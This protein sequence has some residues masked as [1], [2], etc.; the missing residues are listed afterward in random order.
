M[1]LHP[2][3]V[4]GARVRKSLHGSGLAARRGGADSCVCGEGGGE[5]VKGGSV[6]R[7]KAASRLSCRL[8]AT[9]EEPQVEME[10]DEQEQRRRKVEAGRAKVDGS[11][12]L[13][14][15]PWRET[16]RR[17]GCA[18][19]RSDESV[20]GG[21]MGATDRSPFPPPL[22]NSL[23][24]RRHLESTALCLAP[25]RCGLSQSATETHDVLWAGRALWAGPG[26]LA[27]LVV[28]LPVPVLFPRG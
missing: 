5:W 9:G 1:A 2:R 27:S 24:S 20:G 22:R 8:R 14:A 16:P 23:P 12:L 10:E 15:L 21:A 25:P 17:S 28:V 6:N 19:C 4:T 13:P 26:H 18:Y 7:A 11:V 3:S